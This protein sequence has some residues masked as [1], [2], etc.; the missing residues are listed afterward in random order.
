MLAARTSASVALTRRLR[1]PATR[2]RAEPGFGAGWCI[3][4]MGIPFSLRTLDPQVSTEG[5]QR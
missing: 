4:V 3:G 2:S 5:Q 1:R